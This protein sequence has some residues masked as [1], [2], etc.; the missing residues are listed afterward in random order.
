MD[1]FAGS[2]LLA[3]VRAPLV[4]S[5]R[6]PVVAPVVAPFLAP[7]RESVRESVRDPVNIIFVCLFSTWVV[8]SKLW[9]LL[10]GLLPSLL[11][12]KE[13]LLVAFWEWLPCMV[14]VFDLSF[15]FSL[16]GSLGLKRAIGW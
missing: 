16:D 6:A 7:I 14:G 9:R 15:G 3:P 10:A 2:P 12:A 5:A 1:T 11:S 8:G 13:P 4:A